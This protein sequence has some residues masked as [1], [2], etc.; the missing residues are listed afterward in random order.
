[1][2]FFS[3]IIPTYNQGTF[4]SKCLKS[5]FQQSYKD[6]EVIVI[7]NHSND[8][9]KNVLKK[10]KKKIMWKKI[11]NKGVIAKSRNMGIKIARGKWLAFLDSDD[12]WN[13]DRLEIIYDQIRKKNFDILCSGEV[14]KKNNKIINMNIPGPYETSFYKK[15]IL[16]GNR[17]STSATVVKKYF[18]KKKKIIFNEA[19]KFNTCEDYFFF[20]EI[21][22]KDGKFYF[23]KKI[24]GTHRFHKKS[25]SSNLISTLETEKE[26]LKHHIFKVQKFKRN[27]I[28]LW[29][30]AIYFRNLKFALLNFVKNKNNIKKLI[31]YFYKRPFIF[32]YYLKYLTFKKTYELFLKFYIKS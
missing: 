20:L 6:F 21:A 1:M 2:P 28:I 25:S 19:K 13:K 22:S 11:Y 18:L 8:S 7:D 32:I 31:I 26:V 14:F 12:T 3:I 24:L 4:L 15:L 27:S 30:E 23:L 16:T 29:N 17:L 9:T 5:V 10:L